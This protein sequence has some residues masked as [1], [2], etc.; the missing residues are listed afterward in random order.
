MTRPRA[1]ARARARALEALVF[2]A[3]SS[4]TTAAAA[5]AWVAEAPCP[6]R[7]ILRDTNKLDELLLIAEYGAVEEV[8]IVLLAEGRVCARLTRLPEWET[9]FN[10]I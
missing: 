9:V 5:A 10:L 6:A 1:R 7:L 2:V 8:L 4:A 3:S